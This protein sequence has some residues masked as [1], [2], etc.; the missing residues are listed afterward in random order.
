MLSYT[1]GCMG[2]G[3]SAMLVMKE[4]NY[5]KRNFNTIVIKPEYDNRDGNIIKPRPMEGLIVDI[6]Y[7]PT[8]NLYDLIKHQVDSSY[9]N[10]NKKSVV[11]V[12]EV[13]FSTPEHIEQL[14]RVSIELCEVYC[15]G[16]KVSYLNNIFKPISDL[17]V[18]SD[19][20]NELEIDCKYCERKA[21]THILYRNNVPVIKGDDEVVGDF[22]GEERFESV[23]Q[24]CRRDIL[25]LYK[26]YLK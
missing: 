20:I 8:D 9:F 13:Q 2:S 3:K 1:Y 4:F 19:E 21:T 14:W 15:Y 7:K 6:L 17:L 12:D 26:D 22:E 16:L 5:R 10:K 24:K 11:F 25:N 18:Y 23:C